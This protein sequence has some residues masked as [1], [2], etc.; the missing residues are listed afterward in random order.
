MS[1]DETDQ[2]SHNA[3]SKGYNKYAAEAVADRFLKALTEIGGVLL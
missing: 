3:Y 2:F 1:H